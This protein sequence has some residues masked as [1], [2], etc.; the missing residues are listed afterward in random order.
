MAFK[1]STL[2]G[3]E[4][5]PSW[6]SRLVQRLPWL[7]QRLPHCC[8]GRREESKK[9]GDCT[10]WGLW[11]SEEAVAVFC[12]VTSFFVCLFNF[13]VT[14]FHQNVS[15]FKYGISS[16]YKRK[17]YPLNK[18]WKTQKSVENYSQSQQTPSE[19]LN[20]PLTL[21]VPLPFS[22]SPFFKKKM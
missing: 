15:H 5:G 6:L 19:Q 10:F 12:M 13:I 17:I 14:P 1:G 21:V 9:Q 3:R 18:V 7:V 4:Q 11:W 8:A 2:C 16:Y 20:Y 22:S